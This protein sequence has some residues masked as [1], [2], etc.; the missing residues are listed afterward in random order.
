MDISQ[1]R[2]FILSGDPTCITNHKGARSL[3]HGLDREERR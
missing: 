3:G 1:V 2:G